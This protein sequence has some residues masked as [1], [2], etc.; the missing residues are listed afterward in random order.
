M[1]Y[2]F[3]RTQERFV[4]STGQLTLAG[5]VSALLVAALLF[6]RR[7]AA[8]L[9]VTRKASGTTRALIMALAL[10][11]GFALVW[12]LTPFWNF[13]L[14]GGVVSQQPVPP[15]VALGLMLSVEIVAA[16]WLARRRSR[17]GWT[18]K[19]RLA[20]VCGALLTYAWVGVYHAFA[21]GSAAVAEQVV[22]VGAF[23]GALNLV[24]PSVRNA[25]AG[26]APASRVEHLVE[27]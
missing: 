4:A 11:S 24:G 14:Y 6:P 18:P 21:L 1:L 3:T 22:L 20:L 25:E 5:A 2:N 15:F 12:K 17:G 23:V 19:Q 27:D 16:L 7:K 8:A 9:P 10:S 13:H 26:G